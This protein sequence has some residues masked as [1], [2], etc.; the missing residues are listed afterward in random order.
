[1]LAKGTSELKVEDG[2]VVTEVVMNEKA[3]FP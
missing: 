1:M 2:E 3:R